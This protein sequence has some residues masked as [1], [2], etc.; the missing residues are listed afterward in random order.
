MKLLISI[1][2]FLYFQTLVNGKTLLDNWSNLSKQ[3]VIKCHHENHFK[4]DISMEESFRVKLTH[5][6]VDTYKCGNGE[7]PGTEFTF[8]GKVKDF[9][10]EGP[11][12]LRIHMENEE[13]NRK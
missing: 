6:I 7:I 4:W 13:T 2:Y 8:K 10:L 1:F 9:K 11:G 12:K 5:K 3:S